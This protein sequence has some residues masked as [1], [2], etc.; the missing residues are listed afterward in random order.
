[1][2]LNEIIDD[3]YNKLIDSPSSYPDIRMWA[4]KV[5]CWENIKKISKEYSYDFGDESY[6]FFPQND[7]K[8][9]IDN[10]ANLKNA[11]LWKIIYQWDSNKNIL[12][13][14]HKNFLFGL[15][16]VIYNDTTGKKKM[17][18]KQMEYA[19]SIFLLVVENGFDYETLL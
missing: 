18:K 15:P 4:R 9:F 17:T 16:A 11:A 13:L 7:A 19:K 3:V 10:E 12:S 6:D 8:L 2:A 5:D 14:K 1:M